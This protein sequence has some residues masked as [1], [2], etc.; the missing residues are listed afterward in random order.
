MKLD[1]DAVEDLKKMKEKIIVFELCKITQ[2]REKLHESL[3]QTQGS[4]DAKARKTKV[5]PRGEN[6]KSNKTTKISSFT[7]TSMD[8]KAKTTYD[9][10]KGDPR[11]DGALIRNKFRTQ[12]PPFLLTFEIFNCNVHNCLVDSRLRQV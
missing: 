7:N 5:T 12:T 6:V 3:Q 1:Y 4:E 2:L 8:D 9:K 10:K 11:E